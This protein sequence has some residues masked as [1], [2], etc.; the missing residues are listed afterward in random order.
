MFNKRILSLFLVFCMISAMF[1][2]MPTLVNAEGL[3]PTV[4][5]TDAD[6]DRV[7]FSGDALGFNM[8]GLGLPDGQ[9]VRVAFG[10]I[11]ESNTFTPTA[12]ID[13]LT[14]GDGVQQYVTE[15]VY[16]GGFSTDITGSI[17][18][19]LDPGVA[20][21]ELY[22]DADGPGPGNTWANVLQDQPIT[23]IILEDAGKPALVGLDNMLVMP[24]D[25]TSDPVLGTDAQNIENLY[26]QDIIFQ[27]VIDT[28]I[29]GSISFTGLDLIGNKEQLA[30]LSE[31]LTMQKEV[32]PGEGNLEKY[33]LGVDV[34]TLAFLG[35]IGATVSVTSSSFD[36][37]TSADFNAEAADPG[38]GT[39]SDLSFDDGT[40]TVS[41]TVNHFSNYSLSLIDNPDI[42]GDGYHDGDV[43]ALVAFLEQ[44]SNN[45]ECEGSPVHV[46]TEKN[47][48][49]LNSS[50]NSAD[51]ATFSGVEW[52]S[53]T[54]K[55]VI[56][57]GWDGNSNK[58]W[59]NNGDGL[60]NNDDFVVGTPG[61]AR[62]LS[63]TFDARALS[64]LTGL[65]INRTEDWNTVGTEGISGIQVAGLAKLTT[66]SIQFNAISGTMNLSGCSA[67]T[68]VNCDD[69]RLITEIDLTGCTALETLNCSCNSISTITGIG[70]LTN[71]TKLYCSDNFM[72]TMDFTT[73][74]KLELLD[75]GF[76]GIDCTECTRGDTC[77][78][79][80]D[81]G[82][83]G[84]VILTLPQTSTLKELYC[85]YNGLTTLS[86]AGLTELTDL[87]FYQNSISSIDF[88]PCS[89]LDYIDCSGN[90]LTALDTSSL[91][92]LKS[93]YCN[94]NKLPMS[95]LPLSLPAPSGD[96]VYAPQQL[97]PITLLNGNIVDLSS[98][99]SIDGATT[100]FT[101]YNASDDSEISAGITNVNGVFTFD[102]TVYDN[103]DVYCVMADPINFAEFA[104]DNALKTTEVTIRNIPVL[105]IPD[106]L[107]VSGTTVYWNE[108]MDA[109]CYK[110]QIYND[111][112]VPVGTEITIAKAAGNINLAAFD[113]GV[114]TLLGGTYK[115]KVKAVGDNLTYIDSLLSEYSDAV[116][117]PPLPLAVPTG[118][119]VSG[120]TVSWDEVPN[121]SY[122]EVD[123]LK[124]GV[125]LG[126]SYSNISTGTDMSINLASIGGAPEQVL[127]GGSDY[128]IKVTAKGN[129]LAYGDSPKS[130]ASGAVTLPALRLATPTGFSLSGGT[131]V[132]WNP[133]TGASGYTV[134][135]LKGVSTVSGYG[136][137]SVST[138]S[139]NLA[140]LPGDE[141]QT[142]GGGNDY[143]IKVTAKGNAPAYTDSLESGATD[144]ITLPLLPYEQVITDINACTDAG[145]VKTYIDALSNRNSFG[146]NITYVNAYTDFSNDEKAAV[147]VAVWNNG[148]DYALNSAGKATLITFYESACKQMFIE[149]AKA[150]IGTSFTAVEFVDTNIL[151]SLNDLTGM[152]ETGVTLSVAAKSPDDGQANPLPITL[153]N[154]EITYNS[155]EHTG[156]VTLGL[157]YDGKT[158]THI[159]TTVNIPVKDTIAPVPGGDPAGKITTASVGQN[160]LVLN[161][162]KATDNKAAQSQLKYYVIKS[163]LDN[164][165]DLDS[166]EENGDLLNEDGTFDIAT[167]TVN[168]LLPSTKYYFN[169]ALKDLGRNYAVY[170]SVSVTTAAT[171]SGGG[172]NDGD[173]NSGGSSSITT[174]A[175]ATPTPT[176]TTP[177]VSTTSSA[178]GKTTTAST[179]ANVT[180][181]EATGI[182][183]AKL[184]A[185]TMNELLAKA[186][187]AEA[188]GNKAVIDIKVEAATDAK[189]VEIEIPRAAFKEV[190]EKTKSEVKID[191]GIG[192]IIFD[193]KAIDTINTVGNAGNI[194]ISITKLDTSVLTKEIKEKVG[195]RPVFNFSV[196]A[197][198]E[199]VY[200]F[201]GGN[202]EV[203]IQYT[204]KP[205]EKKN[206]IVVYYIDNEGKLKTVRGKYDSKTGKVTFNTSHFSKYAIGYNEVVFKDVPASA[207]YKGAV[208]FIAA[209]GIASG[210]GNGN[211]SPEGNLTR[212]QFVVMIM[213]AYGIDPIDKP[214]DN[215]ADAGNTYYT[216]YLAAAKKLGIS[217]GIGNNMYAPEKG[218]TRQEM[219]TMLYNALKTIGELPEVTVKK[220]L[221]AFSDADKIA[222]WAKD[223]MA[224]FVETGIVSGSGGKL[225]PA[226]ASNRIQMT[227]VLYNLLSE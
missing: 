150:I 113:G 192:T 176:P 6:A 85:G 58:V 95:E 23:H 199:E 189:T 127:V 14:S 89:K 16:G 26:S 128:T 141:N 169:I 40:D 50:Y 180:F 112:N 170:T 25:V 54:P 132:S 88:S 163:T 156:S 222:S 78:S 138:P 122:Y 167:Y 79:C 82:R 197:G 143:T 123:I 171:P 194:N 9:A 99:K 216:N 215:F 53:D 208:D 93:F 209:R 35:N 175:N 125:S 135:I 12:V 90:N 64:E 181:N 15:A 144:S 130:S 41:F 3:P 20:A 32:E 129:G 220:P 200:K 80:N 1:A 186:T 178:D 134:N 174:P 179:I 155:N 146:A 183:L 114:Q 185:N 152:S 22:I 51:P 91:E 120:T 153:A 161:W 34:G 97:I 92:Y 74:T 136:E 166:M 105:S 211:Y 8:S 69:N 140:L 44:E 84:E 165:S 106:G 212:G 104:G 201:G 21:V 66:L 213:K 13:G 37:L 43:A 29:T 46:G 101:W 214:T 70:N 77:L 207:W 196:K 108:V 103:M 158:D 118:F 157:E 159:I 133:V 38:D 24:V 131:T 42:N 86:L 102:K 33:T 177:Q 83:T 206:F 11:G 47:G 154:G 203:S 19:G 56:R 227:Q 72:E 65:M 205:G 182:A 221:T 59:E 142:L 115:I 160:S 48:V 117:V 67:L 87:D 31:G 30:A 148:S 188:A 190:A 39:A 60:L 68:S 36:G 219:F 164:I 145:V 28:G 137:V 116:V 217:K 226:D 62:E 224:L 18:I 71:L 162:T 202:A 52:N 7:Y 49:V 119:S 5:L 195:D 109:I 187:E 57:I 193:D 107:S 168:G 204:L 126:G 27:K 81:R 173:G 45:N 98:E 198:D 96:Y 184:E 139:I 17:Q 61:H 63:G 75:C 94:G 4:S 2:G 121:T 147:A 151:T 210:T 218:I 172:G 124:A 225:S 223:S 55:R 191:A 100:S 111:S 149:R 110:A 10:V 76:N 73:L